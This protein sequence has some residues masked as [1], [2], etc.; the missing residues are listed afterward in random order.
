MHWYMEQG[1]RRLRNIFSIWRRSHCTPN[2]VYWNKE[3]SV[4][5]ISCAEI[6]IT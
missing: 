6:G 3:R 1:I 2:G 5:E 4:T